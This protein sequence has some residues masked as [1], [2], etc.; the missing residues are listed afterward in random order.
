MSSRIR[1]GRC[2]PRRWERW[3]VLYVV[4]RLL[5]GLGPDDATPAGISADKLAHRSALLASEVVVGL[6]LLAVIVFIAAFASLIRQAG[7]DS[8]P[9]SRTFM[10]SAPGE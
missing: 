5:Q 1:R 8:E 6:A 3:S 4:H 9:E 2:V 7:R 10:S